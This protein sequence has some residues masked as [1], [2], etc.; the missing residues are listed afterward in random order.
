[1]RIRVRRR[2]NLETVLELALVAGIAFG[3]A[4]RAVAPL[5]FPNGIAPDLLFALGCAVLLATGMWFNRQTQRP[6]Y[7]FFAGLVAGCFYHVAWMFWAALSIAPME[8]TRSPREYGIALLAVGLFA[9]A[10]GTAYVMLCLANRSMWFEIVEQDGYLCWHCG[11]CMSG[12]RSPQCPECG[13]SPDRPRARWPLLRRVLEAGA[14]HSRVI[15]IVLLAAVATIACQRYILRVRPM[16]QFL[17]CFIDEKQQNFF[18][19]TFYPNGTSNPR[20]A[21]NA[22]D[23]V[24]EFTY[25]FFLPIS[26]SPDH[27]LIVFYDPLRREDQ[28]KMQIRLAYARSTGILGLPAVYEW[29]PRIICNVNSPVADR[30]CRDS[31]PDALISELLASA[32]SAGWPATE[33]Q[34][35]RSL[36]PRLDGSSY[37][38]VVVCGDR[39]FVP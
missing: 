10:V 29:E 18:F 21:W 25:G 3:F 16:R 35:S 27:C 30:I 19:D 22:H 6:L 37:E 7:L 38:P 1:M 14:Q 34:A 39:F 8:M 24:Y 9:V 36:H 17:H 5:I 4:S 15:A 28:A 31:I 23:G 13:K 33:A 32:V 12:V 11:Y 2:Y 20:S 26:R